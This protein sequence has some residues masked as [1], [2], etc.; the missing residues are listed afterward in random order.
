M[1]PLHRLFSLALFYLIDYASRVNLTFTSQDKT[2]ILDIQGLVYTD[3]G[4]YKC[5]VTTNDVD[6][7]VQYESITNLNVISKLKHRVLYD[8]FRF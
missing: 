1:N 3:E 5:T 8:I 2:L 4:I 7:L 6:S